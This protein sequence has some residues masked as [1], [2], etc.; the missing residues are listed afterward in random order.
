MVLKNGKMV[1]TEFRQMIQG[2]NIVSEK[3]LID[4]TQ[5]EKRIDKIEKMRVR[6][7]YMMNTQIMTINRERESKIHNK[8]YHFLYLKKRIAHFVFIYL[9]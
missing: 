4:K 7:W 9:E 6:V 5:R 8:G 1:R 2:K 3:L